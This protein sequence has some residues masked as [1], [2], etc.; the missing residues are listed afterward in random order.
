[1]N[2]GKYRVLL[3]YKFVKI[4]ESE[5][6][7]QN[8]LEFCKR[9]GVLGRIIIAEEGIN[10]TLSGT[11]KQTETYINEIHKDPKFSDIEFKT[12]DINGHVF[13]KLHVRHK[14]EI[15]TFRSEHDINPNK[16]TGKYLEP[17]EFN[18][19]LQENDVVILD[20]RTD[21]EYN[22]GHFKNAIRP[23]VKSFR[24]FPEWIKKNLSQY[25]DKKVLTYCTGGIR[26]E[27]LSAFMLKEGFKDVYQLHGGIIKYSKDA[28]VKGKHFK[29]KC[30]VFDERISI[31][32]NYAE[33][34]IIT[35]KCLHCGK[36]TD[37]YV[38]CVN[39]DCHKQHFECEECEVKWKRSCSKE[40]MSARR[41]EINLLV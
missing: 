37:R 33:E 12:D 38:N 41:H 16:L 5:A 23:E 8:H 7:A 30:Y 4:E 17:V 31:P 9:L 27:K 13:K 40:C 3:Y 25:K 22:L 6:Y 20:G 32:V 34:Y 11:Y 28:E 26:C 10:G 18:K 2:E 15:V 1:M 14:K 21:Y 35:G 36:S 24:E 29:G 19:A 39:L